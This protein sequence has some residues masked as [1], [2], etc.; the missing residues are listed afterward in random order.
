MIFAVLT[1]AS[2]FSQTFASNATTASL[3][4]R[5]LSSAAKAE[6]V[7]L[8]LLYAIAMTE[9][10]SGGRLRPFALNIGGKPV[11]AKTKEEA[12]SAFKTA[13][14]EDIALIDLGCMQINHYYHNTQFSSVS[15]ML[16]PKQNV[17]YAAKLLGKLKRQHGTWTEAVAR[18]HASPRNKIAQHRYVCKVLSNLVALQF[19]NWTAESR[20]YCGQA[21]E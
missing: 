18:Y 1:T 14:E 21:A 12:L 20:S 16:D 5:H 15:D 3:C 13:R 17:H 2:I 7:P 9:T 10:G 19:G 11:L 8:G 6:D 4:E